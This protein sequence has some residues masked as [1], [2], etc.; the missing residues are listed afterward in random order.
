MNTNQEG[1]IDLSSCHISLLDKH[2]NNDVT[3]DTQ[4][5]AKIAKMLNITLEK[6][7]AHIKDE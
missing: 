3:T 5:Q 4:L 7:L 2:T 1:I 6:I